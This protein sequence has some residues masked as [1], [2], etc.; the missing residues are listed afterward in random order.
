MKFN[1]LVTTIVFTLGFLAWLSTSLH[2]ASAY[3][4]DRDARQALHKLYAKNPKA[5][6]ISNQA[7]AA[8]VFPTIVKAGFIF[9]AQ[10]GDGPLISNGGTVGYYH[11]SAV[12]YGLQAGVQKYSYVLFFMNHRALNYIHKSGGWEVGTGP[13]IVIV[14][15]GMAKSMSIKTLN[16]DVYAFVFSQK[17]LMAGLGLQGSKITPYTPSK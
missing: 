3:E 13:S 2:A 16:K 11:T 10:G 7:T 8:L 14:D 5:A 12:S 6:E 17:G 15:T 1:K 9:G 4:L